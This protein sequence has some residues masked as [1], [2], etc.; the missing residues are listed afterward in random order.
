MS[1]TTTK[2]RIDIV[3]AENE[4]FS[5]EA[6]Y[7]VAMGE[8][9]EVGIAPGH[10]PLLAKLKPGEI[11]LRTGS[12]EDSFYVSSGILEVQPH[13]VTVLAD[14]VARA[15]DLDELAAIQ[16]KERAEKALADKKSEIDFTKANAALAEAVAQL[17][18]ISKLRDQIKHS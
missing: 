2:L 7:I 10:M 18:L 16:A 13:L 1:E 12:T 3:S 4:V 11:R 9:G 6:D 5:G 14:T 15:A 17:R 8:A